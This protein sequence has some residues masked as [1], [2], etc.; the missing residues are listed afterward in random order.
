M[1]RI[2]LAERSLDPPGGARGLAA[3]MIEALKH[4]YRLTLLTWA[5]PDL[6]AVNRFFGTDL[7]DSDF[8]L[9]LVRPWAAGL[10]AMPPRGRI[11]LLRHLYLVSCARRRAAGFDAVI[12]TNNE[13]DVGP[14]GIQYFHFP[15]FIDRPKFNL[16]WKHG[17]AA[18]AIRA[19]Q[20]ASRLVT[21]FSVE[22]MRRNL[23]MVNS[24]FTGRLVRELH[25]IETVTVYPPAVGTFPDIPWSERKNG[26]VC[27]GRI[28]RE[29]RIEVV[30]DIL[31]AVRQAGEDVR[32]HLVGT[33]DGSRYAASI[34]RLIE[35]N[36]AWVHLHEDLSR[37]QL[38]E[39]ITA[40]RYGIHG[41]LGEPFGMA[42]AELVS[43]GCITFV[44]DSGG[45]VEIVGSDQHLMY[46]SREDAV[47]KILRA[48][49]ET[50][51]QAALHRKLAARKDMFSSQRF[52]IH[53]REVI[54]DFFRSRPEL[55]D[56]A[57][58]VTA[59]AQRPAWPGSSSVPR[60]AK[61]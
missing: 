4:E 28:S 61:M 8:A 3:W 14:R 2:L 41:M 26:F 5:R 40:N 19:Y 35:A 57:P 52:V 29:K 13:A 24:D 45:P 42:V 7:H 53:I 27:M 37:A 56:I 59:S 48:L 17:A 38:V 10:A 32:L 47:A 1:K 51:Y 55:S 12:G 18:P 50:G 54:G 15:R 9:E 43:G 44:P 36:A 23:T 20:A 33:G 60:Q 16:Q 46:S 11:T 30:I 34:R 25:G 22:R 58:A 21:G 6:E 39:L 49:R 31:A